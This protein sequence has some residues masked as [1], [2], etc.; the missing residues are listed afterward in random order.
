MSMILGK[1][2]NKRRLG[3]GAYGDVL[4]VEDPN[5]K[6]VAIKM[7]SKK[8]FQKD[9]FMEEY[10]EGEKECMKTVKSQYV[11]ELLDFEEDENYQYF[12]CEYCD[13]GDLLNA[14]AKQPNKV[15]ELKKATEIM[16]EV[17]HG[18]ELLHSMGY[19]H[20]DIKSQN[21]LLKKDPKN[22]GKYVLHPS[23]SITNSQTSGSPRSMMK[24]AA[25]SWGPN[26]TC[27]P[28]SSSMKFMDSKWICG[29]LGFCSTLC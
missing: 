9:P 6:E 1:Y 15:F 19:L 12:I 20:R 26:I 2:K 10:L 22:E 7:I 5:G 25:P 4:L 3:K 13:G 29:P 16:A 28:K 11:M 27:R 17:I 18:L 8:I 23:L 21:I 24:W 14:Q